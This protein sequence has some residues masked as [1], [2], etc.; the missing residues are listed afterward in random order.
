MLGDIES[1]THKEDCCEVR[2]LGILQDIIGFIAAAREILYKPKH[3][4][5]HATQT[6]QA[7][8]KQQRGLV[9]AVFLLL[10]PHPEN[11][12]RLLCPS[13]ACL[14]CAS[15]GT[16]WQAGYAG[17][18]ASGAAWVGSNAVAA[19]VISSLRDAV[20]RRV[21][22]R[23]HASL[24]TPQVGNS[25]PECTLCLSPRYAIQGCDATVE[26]EPHRSTGS[27]LGRP[28]KPHLG[29]SGK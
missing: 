29:F 17:G 7:A 16:D 3:T 21:S 19:G 8:A 25:L 5:T 6:P 1:G 13:L 9:R 11:D 27:G 10:L 4:L 12:T 2:L 26:G 18:I 14:G 24:E 20:G 22:I 15:S 23:S 28:V